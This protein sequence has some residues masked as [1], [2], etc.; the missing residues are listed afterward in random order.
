M[1]TS[2]VASRTYTL[3]SSSELAHRH[4]L[5]PN[6]VSVVPATPERKF[7]PRPLQKVDAGRRGTA[8]LGARN[9]TGC[10]RGW[11]GG[12]EVAPASLAPTWPPRKASD[13]AKCMV[14]EEDVI[15]SRGSRAAT[16]G[17][18]A[19][20]TT[21]DANRLSLSW[22]T[23]A[24]LR[25]PWEAKVAREVEICER[26]IAQKVEAEE[27]RLRSDGGGGSELEASVEQQQQPLDLEVSCSL[28]AWTFHLDRSAKWI[29]ERCQQRE[30]VATLSAIQPGVKPARGGTS[31][32]SEEKKA[33]AIDAMLSKLA[34]QR[35]ATWCQSMKSAEELEAEASHRATMKAFD[36]E[37]S[38]RER[39]EYEWM[40]T[41]YAEAAQR[42]EAE[43]LRILDAQR[44]REECKQGELRSLRA[45]GR[46]ILAGFR[47]AYQQNVKQLRALE[48]EC[49]E[50]EASSED[51]TSSVFVL[52]RLME[53]RLDITEKCVAIEKR[54][55][56][57]KRHVQKSLADVERQYRE[58]APVV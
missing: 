54:E 16:Y 33:A 35:W 46:D 20:T 13:I 29:E 25:A 58:M 6:A 7:R 22:K 45:L 1:S 41:Y 4:V 23:H 9:E 17:A 56:E 36:E 42:A 34:T 11:Q 47:A 48:K 19:T 57:I 49:E 32:E 28:P 27:E 14:K 51:G 18:H 44:K 5:I 52:V 55:K 39:R 26:E 12:R 2:S 43:R 30:K 15:L 40:R 3:L 8:T 10:R 50:A 38:R 37:W 31:F 24:E 53:R 21:M